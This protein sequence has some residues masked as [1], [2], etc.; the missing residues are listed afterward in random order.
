MAAGIGTI[1]AKDTCIS[2]TCAVG[3]W[4]GCA[5]VGSACTG[6]I[7]TRDAFARDMKPR[8]LAELGVTLAGQGIND[9]CYWLFMGLVFTSMHSVS[10]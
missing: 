5:S 7:C 4:I 2:S 1:Y 8:A 6:C 9:C 3:I 10:C